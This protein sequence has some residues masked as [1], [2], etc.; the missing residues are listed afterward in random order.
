MPESVPY[1]KAFDF[2]IPSLFNGIDIIAPSGKFC[3]AIP[4]AKANAPAIVIPVFPISAPAN[5]TP[6]AI[7]SGILW[8]VTA[9]TIIVVFLSFA[10]IPSVL[11]L[12]K[13]KCGITLSSTSKKTI[14][15]I[16]PTAAGIHATFPCSLAISIDGII[17]DH[18]EAASITPDAKPNS[19]FSTFE[20][21]LF[22]IKNTIAEPSV[23]PKKGIAKP[24]TKFIKSPPY[25]FVSIINFK[26]SI[27]LSIFIIPFPIG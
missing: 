11:S 14:P 8:S 10:F 27:A 21:I 4:I 18:I 23:V 13:C 15:S 24:V 16:N 20:F 6:T 3:I 1:K 17:K 22:F 19:N 5:V 7:P 26:S 9:N 25:L 2:D 12:F